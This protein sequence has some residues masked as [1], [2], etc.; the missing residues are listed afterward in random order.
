MSTGELAR[1]CAT[2]IF[3]EVR[4]GAPF[5]ADSAVVMLDRVVVLIQG[6]ITRALDEQQRSVQE[7]INLESGHVSVDVG[8]TAKGTYQWSAK[9]VLP[10][11]GADALDDARER[12]LEQLRQ[13]ESVLQEQYGRAP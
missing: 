13:A 4:R 2:E 12:A 10:F 11:V 6:A 9:V 7:V 3:D 5:D 8:T 1:L